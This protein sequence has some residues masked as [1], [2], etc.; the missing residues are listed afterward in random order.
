MIEDLEEQVIQHKEAQQK[1]IAGVLLLNVV[2]ARGLRIADD[3]SSD[4]Y[5]V[6][7][8]PFAKNK[9]ISTQTI[10]RSL[11]PIWDFSFPQMVSF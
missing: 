5:A 8:F 4:P 11:S 3:D 6:V 2:M 1:V 7:T 10:K 9:S